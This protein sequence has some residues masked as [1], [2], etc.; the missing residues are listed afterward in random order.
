M[1]NIV[2]ILRRSGRLAKKGKVNYEEM[3]GTYSYTEFQEEIRRIYRIKNKRIKLS[4]LDKE[5]QTDF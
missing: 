3:M 2:S 4:Q 1:E 5:T